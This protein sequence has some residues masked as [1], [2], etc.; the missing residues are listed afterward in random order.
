MGKRGYAL[1]AAALAGIALCGCAGENTGMEQASGMLPAFS[2]MPLTADTA[3]CFPCTLAEDLVVEE[4]IAYSGAF[5]EDGSGKT[6]SNV[7]ALMV[8]NTGSRMMEFGVITL[9]QGGRLL[10][11]FVYDLPPGSRCLVAERLRHPYSE[12]AVRACDVGILQWGYPEMSREEVNYVGTD[13]RLTV[14]NRTA[15]PRDI[16]VRYKRY[17]PE[18]DYFLGGMAFSAHFFA[19]EPQIPKTLT[20]EHYHAGQARVVSVTTEE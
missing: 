15:R 9:E 18:G 4:L 6:V 1:L 20:P 10:H 16:L 13:E 19:A 7:A 3:V 5:W 8:A 12:K 11:F 17:D 14:V 2:A